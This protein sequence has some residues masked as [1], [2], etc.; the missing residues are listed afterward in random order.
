MARDDLELPAPADA[1]Q[2]PP[3][4][5]TN[6]CRVTERQM[7]NRRTLVRLGLFRTNRIAKAKN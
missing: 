2:Q 1:N 6:T 4:A 7:R 3:I 5:R